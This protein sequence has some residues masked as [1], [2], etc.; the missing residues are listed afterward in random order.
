MQVVF[1]VGGPVQRHQDAIFLPQVERRFVAN[2]LH[3]GG[4]PLAFLQV[5]DVHELDAD[6]PGIGGL[7]HRQQICQRRHAVDAEDHRAVNRFVEV[8][9]GETEIL[10]LQQRVWQG[11]VVLK[12]INMSLE[13]TNLPIPIDQPHH[14]G[15]QPEIARNRRLRQFLPDAVSRKL[16]P[17][18]ERLP[19]RVHRLRAVLPLQVGVFDQIAVV[20]VGNGQSGHCGVAPK[21]KPGSNR[22]RGIGSVR[23]SLVPRPAPASVSVANGV[24]NERRY[25]ANL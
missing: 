25:A 23:L 12:G 3:A 8:G 2:R 10:Q 11:W 22:S 1:K 13:V 4:Q 19:R 20:R 16:R 24:P 5:V 9:I 21:I 18:E 14:A 6:P 17:R 15:L 7:Q